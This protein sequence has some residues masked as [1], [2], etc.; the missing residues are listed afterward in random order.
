[1]QGKNKFIGVYDYTVILTYLSLLS[2]VIGIAKAAQGAYTFAVLCLLFS[3]VC[4]A[5]DG[6]VA[7]TKKN[8]TENEKGFGIQIDSLCDVI[9]FGVFPAL[10]CYFM[11]MDG[12]IGL[13]I[14]FMYS[15]CAVIR[16]AFFNVL[17]ANRQ[18]KEDGCAKSYRGL[19]VT[20]I[21]ILF[22]VVYCFHRWMPADAFLVVLHVL[23][24]VVA[25]LFVYDFAVPKPDWKKILR[26]P[27]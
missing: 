15:L 13:V 24:A 1:M 10:L 6:V 12:V 2:A 23:M 27:I 19:P 3:G 18:K 17:E 20:S 8:R 4:D 11:G 7:R 16:L 26:L 9:S 21:S 22:P 5:F 25:F 14:V